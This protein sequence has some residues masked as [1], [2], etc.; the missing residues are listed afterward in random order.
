MAAVPRLSS[1]LRL[2]ADNH[3]TTEIL[4]Q[5]FSTSQ[6]LTEVLIRDPELLDWLQGGPERGIARP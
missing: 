5:V 1:T 2:L 3:R 6:Y 4:L